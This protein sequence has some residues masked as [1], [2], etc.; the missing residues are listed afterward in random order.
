MKNLL[1]AR[2]PISTFGLPWSKI[3]LEL[4]INCIQFLGSP[5]F[6]VTSSEVTAGRSLFSAV[7]SLELLL[8][9]GHDWKVGSGSGLQLSLNVSLRLQC[10][11]L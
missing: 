6:S 11:E 7:F 8:G 3:T 4:N 10:P 2:T 1:I 5:I 9:T